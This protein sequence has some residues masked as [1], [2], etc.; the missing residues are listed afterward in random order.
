MSSAFV[1]S[2]TSSRKTM[3]ILNRP[4]DG[5]VSVLLVLRRAVH[6]YGPMPRGRLIELCAP[7][8]AV[9]QDSPASQMMVWK[10]LHRWLQLGLFRQDGEVIHLAPEFKGLGLDDVESMRTAVLRLLLLPEN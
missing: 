7:E 10:T 1:P 4:S 3:S 8:G 9:R 2:R 6:A 5:L